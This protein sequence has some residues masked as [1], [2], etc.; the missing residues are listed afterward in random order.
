MIAV[1]AS[2]VDVRREPVERSTD[3]LAAAGAVCS[4]EVA[5]RGGSLVPHPPIERKTERYRTFGLLCP[6]GEV[7]DLSSAGMKLRSGPRGPSFAKGESRRW[8][9]EVGKES[10]FV[11]GIIRW[12]KRRGLRQVEIGIEF[13][14]LDDDARVLLEHIAKTGTMHESAGQS[15]RVRASV[16]ILDL[17]KLFHVA[18][19]ATADEIRHAY[20]QL[21]KSLHPDSP[22]GGDPQAMDEATKAWSVLRDPKRRAK[23]DAMREDAA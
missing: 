10:I 4:G 8:S 14:E 16:E 22:G 9:I 11:D 7:L 2:I 12:K 18:P 19:D 3:L 17:Y 6:L 1:H 5:T 13:D 21:V 23:Y 20:R 15:L